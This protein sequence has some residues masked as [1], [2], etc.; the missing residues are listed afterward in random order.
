MTKNV[1]VKVVMNAAG[2]LTVVGL[3]KNG[4]ESSVQYTVIESVGVRDFATTMMA[5]GVAKQ[6]A[7]STEK[8]ERSEAPLVQPK[9]EVKEEKKMTEQRYM[10]THTKG[11]MFSNIKR[12]GT[13][14]VQFEIAN[15]GECVIGFARD[16]NVF[17]ESFNGETKEI[18]RQTVVNRLS[19]Y[20]GTDA[21]QLMQ[22]INKLTPAVSTPDTCS[23]CTSGVNHKVKDYSMRTYDAVLCRDCQKDFGA[24][25]SEAVSHIHG[26]VS[27][28]VWVPC[29]CGKHKKLEHSALCID[30]MDKESEKE[31][32]E[33][34][35]EEVVTHEITREGNCITCGSKEDVEMLSPKGN[36][37]LCVHDEIDDAPI[38]VVTLDDEDLNLL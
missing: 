21:R 34:D 30:C 4:T 38:G 5:A 32:E 11:N 15:K 12:V 10:V 24:E 2:E 14:A 26:S 27:E 28:L 13:R 33:W 23:V 31:I 8:A 35:K 25:R 36:C 9:P 37:V 17:M 18:T 22:V 16:R 19:K 6:H 20:Q 1:N 29:E 3:N 7:A